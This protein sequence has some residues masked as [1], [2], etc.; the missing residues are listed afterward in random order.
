MRF[1]ALAAL[2]LALPLLAKDTIP[3][4]GDSAR[5]LR[6][7]TLSPDGKRVAFTYGGDIWVAPTD[8]GS[9]TRLTLHEAYETKPRW[10]PDGKWIAFDSN[11]AGSYDVWL[12]SPDGGVP[13]Q[14]T[15]HSAADILSSW[16][17]DGKWI[18][19][20]SDRD[21]ET[22]CY[23]VPVGGGTERRLTRH[24]GSFPVLTP[25]GKTL[26][27]TSGT[28]AR[29]I[30]DYKGSGNW[31]LYTVPFAGGIEKRLTTWEGNDMY[32]FVS[33][34]GA[35]VYY[36]SEHDARYQMWKVALAGGE[37]S[38]TIDL[39]GIDITNPCL[40]WDGKTVA[41]ENDYRLAVVP[42]EGGSPTT[43]AVQIRSDVKGYSKHKRTLTAGAKDPD[44]SRD[45]K[46]IAFSLGGDL[47]VMPAG[48]GAAKRLTE[49]PATDE[50][51]RFS[52]DGNEIAYFSNASGNADI[53]L[54]PSEGGSPTQMTTDPKDDFY[55]SW[56]PDGKSLV[57]TSERS[58]NR[59]LWLL[60]VDGGEPTQ[61][62][63]APGGDDDAAFS[64][65][66]KW[67]AYD[68]DRSGNQDVWVMPAEG[69]EPRQVTTSADLDQ[70]P[71]W[72]PDG[73]MLAFEKL[74]GQ[75]HILYVISAD[76]GD[77]MLVS[78]DGE[79]PSFSADGSR[80]LFSTERNGARGIYQMP[81]PKEVIAGAQIPV[82]A[83]TEVERTLEMKQIFEE[84]WTSL[85]NGFYDPN[86]HGVNWAAMKTRYE[87][88][89]DTCETKEEMYY[90]I[91]QMI[92][93]LKASHMGISGEGS[94]EPCA[95][96]GVLGATLVPPPD[97]SAGLV[98]SEVLKGG[99]ADQAWIR[100]GDR[101]L[102]IDG[103]EVGASKS[104]DPLLSGKA[105]H[106]IR[107]RVAPA[108]NP[109]E[110]RE[111]TVKPFSHGQLSQLL[112]DLWLTARKA[113]VEEKGKGEIAYMHLTAMDQDN[114]NFF[115]RELSGAAKDKKALILDVRNNGGGNIHQELI[116][117]LSRRPF[118]ETRPRGSK[119]TA[120]PD[121]TW[122]KPV[123]VLANENSY[124]DAEV[125]PYAFQKVG[126]GPV[127]GVRT[128]GG[129]IGTN[130][131]TLSDGS[132]LRIPRVGWFGID[133]KDM[134]GFGVQP[135]IVVE[136]TPEDR[137]NGR[138]PQLEKAIETLLE[139]LG[140]PAT[141]QAEKPKDGD[142]QK[143]E[144]QAQPK[145]PRRP[146][147]PRK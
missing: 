51:P 87:G 115:L 123:V 17:P 16:S 48:G 122:A 68:S 63:K 118:G 55:H 133:G 74:R 78:A 116:D 72:S 24:G 6:F 91:T 71:T 4:E 132:T 67:I 95:E 82:M 86:L 41:F 142:E 98:A 49:G 52:P 102:A 35:T 114:L 57:F 104:T 39:R 119:G 110:A 32:P 20:D 64:A 59:D 80:I 70:T 85:A 144:E 56:S 105:G 46:W 69:G 79:H 96:T 89:I 84:S 111:V 75:S 83:E 43:I 58:G 138:D 131:I 135:D 25:D 37:P 130:D 15:F 61:L 106:D 101:V 107:V 29:N 139:K 99:P 137:A 12:V 7:P 127:I 31:D 66:G 103:T 126:L 125:F 112:Y 117:V 10:S 28:T 26:V 36:A 120:A 94:A 93:E 22:N 124:S 21:G 147:R 54:I 100:A 44:L 27:F 13:T 18:L 77:E 5:G 92:G 23:A 88:L 30:R 42:V 1:P 90:F 19:F 81:A 128:P 143:T 129:V 2:L 33:P 9:A 40:A 50:W 65:D 140:T 11:R 62:T 14:L 109:A 97:G 73:R 134:E 76:G 136:E 141:T 8:G 34:D 60:P 53:Y 38:A 108:G 121:L 45:G 3:T 47:W 113:T 145:S 146:H